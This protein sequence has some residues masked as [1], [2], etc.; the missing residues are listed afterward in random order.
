MV[1]PYVEAGHPG[2]I[3]LSLVTEVILVTMLVDENDPWSGF[4][5]ALPKAK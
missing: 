3:A 1:V 2:P 4:R 5:R